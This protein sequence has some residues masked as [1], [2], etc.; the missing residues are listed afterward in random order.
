MLL[1]FWVFVVLFRHEGNAVFL[2]VLFGIRA[3]RRVDGGFVASPK[4][5]PTDGGNAVGDFDSGKS[6][7]EGKG[8]LAD[9]RNATR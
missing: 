2:G 9:F 3:V 4:S 1:L 8:L 7:A 6:V 5:V